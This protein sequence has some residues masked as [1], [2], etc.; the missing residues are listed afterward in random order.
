[1]S[2]M[3]HNPLMKNFAAKLKLSGK[4]GKVILVAI[5]RKLAHIIFG[6]IKHNTIFDINAVNVRNA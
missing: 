3:Q 2:A 5:M 1:M 4:C 6:L